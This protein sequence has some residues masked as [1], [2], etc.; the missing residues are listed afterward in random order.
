MSA[1]AGALTERIT[2]QSRPTGQDE[3]GAETG[4]WSDVATVWAQAEPLRGREYF[5]AG[6]MQNAADVRFRLRYRAGV[7]PSMRVLWRGVAHDIVDVIDVG[8]Q[9]HTLELMTVTGVRDG[10]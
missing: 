6:Q 8:G 4:S 3:L 9:R 10:R 2:L 5:A 1:D 7:L